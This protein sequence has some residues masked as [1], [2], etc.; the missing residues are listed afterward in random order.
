MKSLSLKRILC[1]MILAVLIV[2]AIILGSIV[3][4]LNAAVQRVRSL[5]PTPLPLYGS[6]FKVTPD[7]S[8]PTA[9]PVIRAGA[10]GDS[11]TRLQNRLKEL[12]YYSGTVDGQFGPGT[13]TAVTDFQ[14]RHGL[15]SDGVVGP[16][17]SEILYSASAL[18]LPAIPSKS[19][20]TG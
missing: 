13:R 17:T 16:D 18:P 10:M 9:E 5:T 1:Y 15:Q 3:L 2:T 7:P 12:G 20:V 14:Q 19:T 8:A 11:V 4:P 6:V